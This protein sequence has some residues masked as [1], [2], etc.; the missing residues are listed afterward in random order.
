LIPGADPVQ[1]WLYQ[2]NKD[3]AH[4]GPKVRKTLCFIM[5]NM[6]FKKKELHAR[7][8]KHQRRKCPPSSALALTIIHKSRK[9]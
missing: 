4:K 2:G 6:P 3:L 1:N 7:P 8:N 5:F 9:T